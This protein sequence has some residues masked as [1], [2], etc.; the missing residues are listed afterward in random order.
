MIRLNDLVTDIMSSQMAEHASCVPSMKPVPIPRDN[1]VN[2][3]FWPSCVNVQ[4]CG[5]CCGSDILSCVPTRVR[6]VTFHVSEHGHFIVTCACWS[7]GRT[8]VC[9]CVC[10]CVCV[11]ACEC[12]CAYW[13]ACVKDTVREE[14]CVAANAYAYAYAFGVKT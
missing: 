14:I 4:R 11:R 6:N 12:V 5:G 8:R 2:G 1:R 3:L 7:R 13:R 10:V 9:V